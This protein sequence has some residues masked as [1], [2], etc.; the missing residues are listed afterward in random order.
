MRNRLHALAMAWL[1]VVMRHLKNFIV[2][3]KTFC[4]FALRCHKDH[5][6]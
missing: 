2:Y 3:T 5:L 1:L 4:I 6:I